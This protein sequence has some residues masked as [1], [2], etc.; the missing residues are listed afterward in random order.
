MSRSLAAALA[1]ARSGGT[2]LLIASLPA[3]DP[4]LAD[5]A[6]EGGASVIKVHANVRHRAG[7]R[8]F[9]N[10]TEEAESIRAIRAAHPDIPLGLVPGEDPQTIAGELELAKE[11]GFDFISAYSHAA[12][13]AL[14]SAELEVMLA[15]GPST[16][17]AL[18]TTLAGNAHVL[19]A[20]IV[21][22]DGYGQPM[23]AEDVLRYAQLVSLSA[24]PV[25]VPTQ[26]HLRPED[27]PALIR[28]GVAGLMFG[29]V[30]AGSTPESFRRAAR[31]YRQVLP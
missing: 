20:S 18:A 5:A 31:A 16:P 30:V 29:A 23:T 9:G 19:E 3:N 2:L 10:L 14:P 6:V 4:D 17:P 11:L 15:F 13:A 28:G 1:A 21:P 22:G 25:V 12:P 24:L 7:G 8:S 27:L 26:R